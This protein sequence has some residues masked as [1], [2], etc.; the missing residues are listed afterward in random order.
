MFE[1]LWEPI[2]FGLAFGQRNFEGTPDDFISLFFNI[3]IC[4]FL[5]DRYQ[6]LF[7]LFSNLE[8][9]NAP[10]PYQDGDN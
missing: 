5:L 8:F 9:C 6:S 3:N 10:P 7:Y 4:W 2:V 1:N